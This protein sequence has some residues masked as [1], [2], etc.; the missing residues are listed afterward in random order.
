[1]LK[2]IVIN[3]KGDNI[4]MSNY[5]DMLN[6][7]QHSNSIITTN[8]KFD[9][10]KNIVFSNLLVDS[11]YYRYT[12]D[13]YQSPYCDNYSYPTNLTNSSYDR[14]YK[15]ALQYVFKIEDSQF[16]VDSNR[17][18]ILVSLD[19]LSN[20][21]VKNSFIMH[22]PNNEKT[23]IMQFLSSFRNSFAHGGFNIFKDDNDV[24]EEVHLSEKKHKSSNVQ[25]S[26][27]LFDYDNNYNTRKELFSISELNKILIYSLA[28]LNEFILNKSGFNVLNK[29]EE[30]VTCGEKTFKMCL[31]QTNTTNGEN[32]TIISLDIKD[33]QDILI[34]IQNLFV[35]QYENF[36]K[37]IFLFY[38]STSRYTAETLKESIVD[39]IKKKYVCNSDYK[40]ININDEVEN[41]LL[42]SKLKKI[43]ESILVAFDKADLIKI[44]N[45]YL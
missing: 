26:I 2:Y 17:A 37:Y 36:K 3:I 19:G 24:V 29:Q 10:Q 6:F 33:K 34:F 27:R 4:N 13:T 5:V 35:Y 23:F 7:I 31:L 16:I 39:E 43:E 20:F 32:V 12:I 45:K 21:N 11:L 41:K 25:L 22:F 18:N 42:N 30:I 40:D 38:N 44:K 1:M 15:M 28:E 9:F 8:E 14:L